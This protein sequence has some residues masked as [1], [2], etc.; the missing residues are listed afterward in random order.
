MD[1]DRHGLATVL[2][3]GRHYYVK[4]D[5]TMLQVVTSDNWAD[6]FSQGLVRSREKGKVSYHD[7]R[8]RRIIAP[9]YDWG[10]PF[11]NGRALVCRGCTVQQPD[12]EGH[13]AVTDGVWGYIDMKGSEVVPVVYTREEAERK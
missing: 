9:V 7:R 8:F 10:F 13:S 12:A 6:D 3:D 2:V 11:R 5:G 1:F 4:R